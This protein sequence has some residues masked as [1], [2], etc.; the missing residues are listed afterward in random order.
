[1][2][3]GEVECARVMQ[4]LFPSHTF[5]KVRPTWL[6]NDYPG[7][8]TPA[9]PLELDLYCERLCLAVEYNGPQHYRVTPDFHP[10]GEKSLYGQT[11]RDR[12]KADKC[13]ERGIDL[14]VVNSLEV[15]HSDICGFLAT[16]PGIR[17][18]RE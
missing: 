14:I 16:H 10:H 13:R 7:R 11:C 1:M 15:V 3:R 6:L 18:R 9:Q 2:S 12:L 8:K 5:I 17:S 4:L